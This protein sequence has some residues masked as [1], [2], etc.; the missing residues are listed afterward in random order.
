MN[1]KYTHLF[2]DLDNTLWDF[3][4]NSK[5]AMVEAFN[6]YELQ[7]QA[8]FELF[9]NVYSKH[10]TK[11][12]Q[13]YRNKEVGKKELIK[14]RF[15]NTFKDLGIAGVDPEEMN[16]HY[17]K[18]M[19]KQKELFDGVIDVL[20][21]LRKK[22]YL[23][24][25]ITNGFREV[26]NEKMVSSGL[27][28]FFSK[29]FISEDIK[30]PKPCREIFEYAVKSANAKKSKSIMIGDDW[31]VDIIGALNFGMDAIHYTNND[32]LNIQRQFYG[33]KRSVN[34]YKVGVFNHLTDIF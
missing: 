12:W 19:P 18:V 31:E 15:E 33:S 23:L 13:S 20:D 34:L 16:N 22:N 8:D 4:K 26:Q 7:N 2:F 17:L 14:K 3:E 24:F 27:D 21:Y 10:N 30:T 6:F 32:Y 5:K 1:K 29:I 28:P 11:L 9:F 25:I